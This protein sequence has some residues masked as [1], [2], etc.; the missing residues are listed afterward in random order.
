MNDPWPP[1]PYTEWLDTY[2]TLHMWMQIAGKVKLELSPAW[3]EWWEVAFAISARGITSGPIPYRD[4]I[5]EIEFDFIDHIASIRTSQ[6]E[7]RK[8]ALLPKSVANFYA[9]CK[10]AL[11]SL[12]IRVDINCNPVECEIDI[13]FMNDHVHR[14][15][16]AEYVNR[17]WRILAQM[18]R[19]LQRFRSG[20]MGKS[21]PVQFYWGGFD[22]AHSRFSGRLA[23]PKEDADHMWKVTSDEEHFSVGFW[24]GSGKLKEPAFYAYLSPEPEGAKQVAHYNTDMSEYILLYEDLRSSSDPDKAILEFFGSTYDVCAALAGWDRKLLE[25]R[26]R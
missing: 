26:I 5:F 11:E 8:I 7:T 21:T 4:R 22:L 3:N 14:S 18:E 2:E 17:F 10:A 16:D 6:G 9:E 24:P 20:F 12:D 1:L 15:Y 25:R 13:P 19:V 23:P